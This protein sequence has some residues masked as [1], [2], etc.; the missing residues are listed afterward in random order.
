[1]TLNIKYSLAALLILFAAHIPVSD[2]KEFRFYTVE[3]VL[4]GDTIQLDTGTKLQYA[5]IKAPPMITRDPIIR[6]FAEASLE[7]NRQLVKGKKIR[8]EWGAKLRTDDG[9]YQPYIFLEDGTFVNQKILEA[10][11][12]K[13]DVQPPNLK[14]ADELRDTARHSRRDGVGLWSYEDPKLRKLIVIGNKNTK[15][16]YYADSPELDDM[17]KSH[18]EKFS[19]SVEALQHGYRP[20]SDYRERHSQKTALF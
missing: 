17:P 19:S 12:A 20:S 7:Y 16:F 1:M 2:A 18:T 14:Y 3:K 10:G 11:Y 4:S 5:C 13:S 8:V 9:I 15:K 6:D